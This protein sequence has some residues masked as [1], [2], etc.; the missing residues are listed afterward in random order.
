[1]VPEAAVVGIDQLQSG[2]RVMTEDAILGDEDGAEP[3]RILEEQPVMAEAEADDD[4]ELAAVTVQHFG[5]G[6]RVAHRLKGTRLDLLMI[7]K[8]DLFLGYV[9]QFARH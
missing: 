9:P 7:C 5:L 8:T 3:L 1:M 4:V 6:D 2:N